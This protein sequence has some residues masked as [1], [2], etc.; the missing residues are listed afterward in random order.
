[1]WRWAKR[2][3]KETNLIN[4][5]DRPD[6]ISYGEYGEACDFRVQAVALTVSDQPELLAMKEMR[7]LPDG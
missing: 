6:R 7:Q 2:L 1:M 4:A 3:L 5:V